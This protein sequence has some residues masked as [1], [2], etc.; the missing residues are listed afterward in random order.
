MRTR[1]LVMAGIALALALGVWVVRSVGWVDVTTATPMR[2]EARTNPFYAAQQFVRA[3]GASASWDRVRSLPERDSVLVISGWR[4]DVSTA[5]RQAVEAWVKN[6]GRVV[7]DRTVLSDEAFQRWSG[8]APKRESTEPGRMV[9]RVRESC[10]DLR[11]LVPPEAA[12]LSPAA[13][14]ACN[15]SGDSHLESA[16]PVTWGLADAKGPQVVRVS[17]GEGSVTAINGVV[18]VEQRLLT[19]DHASLFLLA[20]ELKTG[21]VVHFLSE[22]EYPSL[23]ALMWMKGAPAVVLL[24][25][26]LALWLWRVTVRFGPR[27]SPD[28]S[29]RRSLE[30]QIRG[31]GEFAKRYEGGGPLLAATRRALES[32][33]RRRLRAYARLLPADR[34]AVLARATGVPPATLAAGTAGDA[35]HVHRLADTIRIVETARRELLTSDRRG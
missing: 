13:L 9:S 22:G 6:G 23:L 24:L 3:L 2:G 20:T 1:M 17:I 16:K 35:N 11:P 14:G 21:D 34:P 5:R 31:T 8:V 25:V 19:R 18:F 32:V 28:P 10:V 15:I 27:A 29:S 26:C 33:A 30:E 4:W 12:S 7:V